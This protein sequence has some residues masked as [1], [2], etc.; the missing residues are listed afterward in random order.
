MIGNGR[1]RSLL[2]KYLLNPESL[3]PTNRERAYSIAMENVWDGGRGGIRTHGTVSRTPVF[4]TGSLNH[5]DT[6]PSRRFGIGTGPNTSVVTDGNQIRFGRL[7]SR[8]PY[9]VNRSAGCLRHLPSSDERMMAER[10]ADRYR[11][12]VSV[13]S[14]C[15]LPRAECSRL[16]HP[17][18][19]SRPRPPPSRSAARRG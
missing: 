16:L 6:L 12:C 13:P 17:R 19:P 1:R 8:F 15:G 2:N 3:L 4:K 11:H 18:S 9:T 10:I 5:S 7:Y 14:F